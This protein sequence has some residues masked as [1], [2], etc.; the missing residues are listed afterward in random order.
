MSS[1]L[2]AHRI[3]PP[4]VVTAP[5]NDSSTLAAFSCLLLL[6][7]LFS[8]LIRRRNA[9]TA[10]SKPPHR[11]PYSL[12][13]QATASFSASRRLG[14]GGFG[15]VFS[16]SLPNSNKPIA[17]KLMDSGSLQGER[18]FQ[19][20][21]FFAGIL[22]SPHTVPA[23]GFSF[24]KKRRRMLVVYDLMPNGNLQQVLLHRKCKE[25]MEW[26][27]RFSVVLDIARGIEYLH[28]LDPPVIHG[29]LKP[30]NILLDQYFS[31]KIGDFGLARVK[32]EN[33]E[34]TVLD[35]D[36]SKPE[37]SRGMEMMKE[38]ARPAEP[39]P[40]PEVATVDD[41]IG[42]VLE[43]TE[44]V[45]IAGLEEYSING[46]DQSPESYIKITISGTSPEDAV[47]VASPSRTA[48]PATATSPEMSCFDRENLDSGKKMNHYRGMT[49]TPSGKYWWLKQDNLTAETG[50]VKE[51][52]MEWI[53]KSEIKNEVPKRDWS[54]PGSSS[55]ELP[56]RPQ[57]NKRKGGKQ[58]EW[59]ASMDE[60]KKVM[61]RTNKEKRRPAREW[62]KEE[63]CEE[64]SR[65]KKNK[66][67]KQQ[68]QQAGNYAS[69]NNCSASDDWWT[70]DDEESYLERKKKKFKSR[71]RKSSSQ[72]NLDQWLDGLS[73]DLGRVRWNSYD[74]GDIPFSGGI[75]STPSM[76]G[77]V[78]YAAPEYNSGGDLSEKCDVYSFGVLLLVVVAGR[79]PLDVTGS[80]VSEYRQAN[81]IF[82]ARHLAR[83]GKLIDLVDK[84]IQRL[85]K[86]Q[87]LLTITVALL[88]LQKL[89]V[90]RP[91]MK[92][93]VA[94]LTG[95]SD[96]PPLPPEFSPSTQY[97]VPLK[98][99]RKSQQVTVSSG[100]NMV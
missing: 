1:P 77:T 27:N 71:S 22:K 19:N 51:F 94:M 21:L 90:R 54:G 12:L 44:S 31:A 66:K 3:H 97:R 42:S 88:C 41:D 76:R 38:N 74:S 13:R 91:S 45:T 4:A 99:R 96:P 26:K 92:E 69:D 59:W 7:L 79:R 75:S 33:R 83:A 28:S 100:G 25:L 35:G 32:T 9:T 67:K 81:L 58:L 70:R 56:A 68:Q 47:S 60:V 14:Q 49:K 64:L 53:G 55:C 15:S 65:K 78:C 30:S 43:K 48:P 6:S 46:L 20:E 11:Y 10:D 61:T 18:E 34:I 80:P 62:W 16:G 5:V 50:S 89:P 37:G 24:N 29:D 23:L 63:Y 93:V 73:G 57:K 95:A 85:D 40:N 87:A 82:W 98:S 17:V 2:S 86:G 36:I 72:S 39:L 8:R 84:S 52:V